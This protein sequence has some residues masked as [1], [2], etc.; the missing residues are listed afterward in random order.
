MSAPH[1][2]MSRRTFLRTSARLIA[3]VLVRRALV[4]RAGAL[5]APA[6]AKPYGQGAYGQGAYPSYKTYL[7][8][9][10]RG[11]NSHGTLTSS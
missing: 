6:P 9:V 1:L 5:Q 11:G 4:A 10:E 2:P 8:F 7:P 3:L